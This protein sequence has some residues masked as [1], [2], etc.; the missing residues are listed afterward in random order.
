M[1]ARLAPDLGFT[2]VKRDIDADPALQQRFTAIVPVVAAGDTVVAE[3]PVNED[4]LRAALESA[5]L[6]AEQ[7]R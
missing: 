7:R 2:V 5:F 4:V 3:A 6:A 1:L